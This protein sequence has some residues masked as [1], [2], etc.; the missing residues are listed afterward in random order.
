MIRMKCWTLPCLFGVCLL[1]VCTADGAGRH[2][3]EKP[4][5]ETPDIRES[6]IKLTDGTWD[7]VEALIK[8]HKGKVVVVDIWSTSCLPCMTEYPHLIELQQRHR[9]KVVCISFNVDYVGI[10]NK[11]SSF[12]RERVEKFLRKQ[13]ATVINVLSTTESDKVFQSLEL[14]SIPAVYVFGTDGKLSKRFDESLLEDGEEEAFTYAEDIDPF[15]AELVRAI[16]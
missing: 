15:V 6:E 16:R 5:T 3:D 1:T 4:V 14:N 10:K 12:Y 2:P 8:E 13:K 11:P 9:D 7:D